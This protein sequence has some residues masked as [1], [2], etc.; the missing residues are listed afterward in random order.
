MKYYAYKQL[1][2]IYRLRN[3]YWKTGDTDFLNPSYDIAKEIDSQFW[4]TILS[5]VDFT[6]R[7]HLPKQAVITALAIFGYECV[8]GEEK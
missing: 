6:T 3:K 1:D 2:D 8:E 7:K 4:D 5:I